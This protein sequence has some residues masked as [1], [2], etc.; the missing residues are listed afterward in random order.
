MGPRVSP[1]P[2]SIYAA[3]GNRPHGFPRV[4]VLRLSS[5]QSFRSPQIST[6]TIAS[7]CVLELPRFPH[8]PAPPTVNLRVAPNLRSVCVA[9]WPI[10]GFPAILP[11]GST[12][13]RILGSRPESRPPAAPHMRLQV[14]PAPASAAGSMMNP[15]Q[16]E[17]CILRRSQRMNLR[18]QSGVAY[19]SGFGCPPDP[20]S[21]FHL[22][23]WPAYESAQRNRAYIV[24]PE[25]NCLPNSLQVH[26]LESELRM[27]ES[28]NASAKVNL[29]CGFHNTWC[30]CQNFLLLHPHICLLPR[31]LGPV[32]HLLTP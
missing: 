10:S 17:L 3:A 32:L 12:G 23:D 8:L 18:V 15:A 9:L 14:S 19:S 31:K 5:A 22:P 13:W 7:R 24:L 20:A 30:I 21:S 11:S 29:I 4:S 16:L 2:A 28:V 26:Q 25:S 27:V 6:P 1:L